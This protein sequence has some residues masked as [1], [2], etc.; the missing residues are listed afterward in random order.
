MLTAGWLKMKN[1]IKVG[2]AGVGYMG[3]FHVRHYAANAN[4]ELVG[5]ADIDE[6]RAKRI[7][8][9]YHCDWYADP[10]DLVDKVEAVSI[11]VPSIE[12]RNV[13]DLFISEGVHVL[14]E[15][16]LASTVDDAEHIVNQANR[17][18]VQLMV[19]HQERFNPAIIALTQQIDEPQYIEAHRLGL[20]SGRGGDVDVITDLMIHDI[21]L[22]LAFIKSPVKSVSALGSSVVTSYLDIANAR[23]EFANGA[24]A[25]VT[26]SRVAQEKVR[27]FQVYTQNEYLNL[28]LLEQTITKTTKNSSARKDGSIIL[29]KEPIEI[30]PN[31]TLKAEIDHFVEIL[32]VGTKPFV[33]GEDGLMALQVA[34]IVR[35]TVGYGH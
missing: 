2:V 25:N 20:F 16:P 5:V 19:G 31:L 23:I 26:A 35:E 9:T 1:R 10:A 34:Q 32:E 12:H 6:S 24:V 28:D 14:M 3:E 15:K 13:A 8:Q 33:T 30:T 4:V 11:A 29:V 7:S 18:N 17:H 22:L 21:D 27:N